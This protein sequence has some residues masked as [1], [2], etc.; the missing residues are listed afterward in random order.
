MMYLEPAPPQARLAMI[1]T[2][3]MVWDGLWPPNAILYRMD[4]YVYKYIFWWG[5]GCGHIFFGTE[6]SLGAANCPTSNALKRVKCGRRCGFKST[7]TS[8]A[9]SGTKYMTFATAERSGNP[10]R[11][12]SSAVLLA[13]CLVWLFTVRLLAATRQAMP[14]WARVSFLQSVVRSDTRRLPS[15]ELRIHATCSTE[16]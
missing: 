8:E 3:S 5:T 7:G 11:S 14:M 9:P 4:V 6:F 2:R 15:H 1:C 13:D 10:D 12:S 16:C